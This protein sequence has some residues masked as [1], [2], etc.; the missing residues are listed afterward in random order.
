[1]LDRVSGLHEIGFTSAWRG[2]P[3]IHT[4]HRS[5]FKDNYGAAGRPAFIGE[6]ANTKPA[7]VGD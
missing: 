3:D 6:V 4:G 7:Y 1:M 5:I 2:T